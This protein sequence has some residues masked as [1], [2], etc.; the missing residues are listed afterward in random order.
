VAVHTAPSTPERKAAES[1]RPLTPAILA[2]VVLLAALWGG[3]STAIKVGLRD[4]PVFGLAGCRF[5]IGVL[6]VWGWTRAKGVPL[7]LKAGE[8]APVLGL[9]VVFAAQIA[10]FNWGTQL[11]QAGRATLILNSYPLFVLLMAHLFVPGDHLS[12]RKIGGAVCAFLGLA[13]V[14]GESLGAGPNSQALSQRA[15]G[16]LIVLLSALLLAA[17]VIAVTRL[18]RRIDPNRLLLWQMLF[19]LPLYF[20]CS[21]LAG[22]TGHYHLSAAGLLAVLYQGIMIAGVC[23]IV[24]TTLLKHYSPSRL[25]VVFFTTPLFGILLGHFVLHEPISA[26]L[27]AG[28]LLVALGIALAQR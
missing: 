23:F 27:G 22:E 2:V 18:V 7:R 1:H 8:I 16:D 24:W 6:V 4:L 15:I 25:S 3:T 28:G 14:F 17:Q 12:G 20:A 11:T 9:T 5:A 21:A 13:V 19:S 10:T 26:H